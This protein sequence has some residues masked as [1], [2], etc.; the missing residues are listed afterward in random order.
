[1]AELYKASSPKRSESGI[2]LSPRERD[3]LQAKGAASRVRA[4]TPKQPPSPLQISSPSIFSYLRVPGVLRNKEQ[5]QWG[6]PHPRL[7]RSTHTHLASENRQVISPIAAQVAH[8]DHPQQLRCN[9]SQC[10]PRH[11]R[12]R[13]VTQQNSPCKHAKQRFYSLRNKRRHQSRFIRDAGTACNEAA[14]AVAFA[15]KHQSQWPHDPER[16]PA[17][18]DVRNA[19]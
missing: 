11:P 18:R 7:T 10:P 15:V 3:S 5:Q 17:N 16:E 19:I 6:N 8:R 14:D 9:A 13:V 1:M 12:H 2:P 4:G